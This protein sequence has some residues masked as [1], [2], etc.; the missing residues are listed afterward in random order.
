MYKKEKTKANIYNII[1]SAHEHIVQKKTIW[2]RETIQVGYKHKTS[3]TQAGEWVKG[4]KPSLSSLSTLPQQIFESDIATRE[5]WKCQSVKV[6]Q[7]KCERKR[8]KGSKGSRLNC[9]Q[10]GQKV[11][12]MLGCD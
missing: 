1:Y 11:R 2:M 4:T 8:S 5:I 3:A 6:P 10:K 7:Q 12:V 9:E